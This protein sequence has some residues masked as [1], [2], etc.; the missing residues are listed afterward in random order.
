M[1][2]LQY[3]PSQPNRRLQQGNQCGRWLCRDTGQHSTVCLHKHNL[4]LT[5]VMLSLGFGLKTEFFRLGLESFGLGLELCG[6]VN[7]VARAADS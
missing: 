2:W 4:T 7:K 6:L 1:Q 5:G 3:H